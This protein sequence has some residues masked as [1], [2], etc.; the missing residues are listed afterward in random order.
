[1]TDGAGSLGLVCADSDTEAVHLHEHN[2]CTHL[3]AW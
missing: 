1:M 3:A 2:L